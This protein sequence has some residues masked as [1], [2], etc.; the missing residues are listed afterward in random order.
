MVIAYVQH[1]IMHTE[2][3]YTQTLTAFLLNIPLPLTIWQWKKEFK[4]YTP[5]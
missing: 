3:L 1:D 4:D 5:E 2:S